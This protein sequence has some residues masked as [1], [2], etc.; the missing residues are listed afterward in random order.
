MTFRRWG[1]G[2]LV[3]GLVALA[4]SFSPF[5]VLTMLPAAD[6]GFIGIVAT[7]LALGVAPICALAASAGVILLLVAAVRRDPY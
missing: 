4:I 5:L 3:W 2:L 6:F 7:M 1:I